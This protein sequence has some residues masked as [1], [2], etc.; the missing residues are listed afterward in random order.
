MGRM[1]CDLTHLSRDAIEAA[2]DTHGIM[3]G[4]KHLG[5][6]YR[7]LR[8]RRAQ[9]GIDTYPACRIQ[10]QV[11]ATLADMPGSTIREIRGAINAQRAVPCFRQSIWE[12]CR[13]L[14][15]H[16]TLRKEGEGMDSRY[17][18]ITEG[19]VDDPPTGMD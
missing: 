7:H 6:S 13:R 2:I 8:I 3:Q 14:V 15:K 10:R 19:V 12:A 5:V 17:W 11:L 9:L 16:G 1:H 18:L 4:A